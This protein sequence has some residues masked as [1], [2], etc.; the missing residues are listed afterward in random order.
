[1]LLPF[2]DGGS[3]TFAKSINQGIATSAEADPE[4][5]CYFRHKPDV[6]AIILK[7]DLGIRT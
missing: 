7:I 3:V 4:D 5:D 6:M 2:N 1:M